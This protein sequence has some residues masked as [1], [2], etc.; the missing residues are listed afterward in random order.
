VVSVESLSHLVLV[1]DLWLSKA[2]LGNSNPFH[3]MGLPP[4]FMPPKLPGSSIDPEARPAFDEACQVLRQRL[5]GLRTYADA[6]TQEELRRSIEAHAG[7]VAAALAVLV[8]ELA[9]HN[10]LINR[11]RISKFSGR[12]R[13]VTGSRV[14]DSRRERRQGSPEP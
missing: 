11:D 13:R 4:R 5:V 12:R 14:R 7:T 8:D 6:L 1:I 3:P 2:I 9:A 10:R